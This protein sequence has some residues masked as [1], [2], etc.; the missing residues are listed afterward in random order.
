MKNMSNIDTDFEIFFEKFIYILYFFSYEMTDP[1][2]FLKIH[3]NTKLLFLLFFSL[4]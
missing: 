4:F 2:N 1:Y 3:F